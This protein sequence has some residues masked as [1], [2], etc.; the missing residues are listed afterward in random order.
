MRT[1]ESLLA[2][3]SLA[4][5]ATVAVELRYGGA[6]VD[7][8]SAHA[9][10]ANPKPAAIY[11]ATDAGAARE[12]LARPLFTPGRRPPS[13]PEH[14]DLPIAAATIPAPV[15]DWRLAGIV[16]EPDRR[17]A[18]FARPGEVR[19]VATGQLI[20]D[21]TLAS[22]ERDS[23]ILKNRD[24]TKTLHIEPRTAAEGGPVKAPSAIDAAARTPKSPAV[25]QAEFA[26]QKDAFVSAI[27]KKLGHPPSLPLALKIEK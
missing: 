26:R 8:N 14:A 11:A 9:E 5:A 2:L 7:E 24:G 25:A 3:V 23:V 12:I 21:W 4:L 6:H 22:I 17:D 13:P 10:A 20:A 16:I 27:S 18:V 19:T 1:L 15:W